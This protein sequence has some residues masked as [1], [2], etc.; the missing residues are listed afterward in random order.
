MLRALKPDG[1]LYLDEYVGPSRTWWTDER[2]RRERE[3]FEALV[4]KEARY[5]ERLPFPIIEN[6]PSEAIRS[7]EILTQLEIGFEIVENRGYGGNLLSI[8]YPAI[9]WD[10]APA[11]L[12][13]R[14]IQAERDLLAEGTPDFLAVIVARPK[15]G[16]ARRIGVARYTWEPRWKRVVAA[17]R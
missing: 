1:L 10:R 4:P 12:L 7:G 15:T 8:I 6:D 13:E 3:I 2:F 11:D 17:A 16:I 9:A 14:L 5:V